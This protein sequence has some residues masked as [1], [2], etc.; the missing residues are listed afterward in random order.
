MSLIIQ[1]DQ[2]IVTSKNRC[3]VYSV[4]GEVASEIWFRTPALDRHTVENVVSIQIETNSHDQGWVFYPEA[5]SWSWFDLVVLESPDATQIKV[6]DGL[7]LVWMSHENKLGD[8]NDTKQAGPIFLGQHDIFA[9]LEVGNSLGVRVCAR[10][11]EWE[12]HALEARLILRVPEKDITSLTKTFDAYLDAAT[13]KEAP[14]AYSLVRE[15]L[16]MGPLRADEV[17]VTEEPPLRLLS[18]DGGGVRGISSLYILQAIMAK[19]SPDNPS[20]KPCE[21]FDM[22]CGTSTGGLIAIMLGRLQMTISECI[23]V[24]ESL[25]SDIF[26]AHRAQRTWNFST[27]G[28]YYKAKYFE[29]GLKNLIKEKTGD[30]NASMLD[31]DPKNKCKVFVVSAHSDNLSEK[32]EHF[33][34]Y[35]NKFPDPFSGC[36]IWQ[37]ARATSAAPMYLPPITINKVE[38][39][40]GGTRFNN[41]SILLMGEVNA[42]FGVA[43]HI[44]CLLSIGTGMQPHITIHSKPSDPIEVVS[45][46]KSII[47]A[48]IKVMT[49]CEMTHNLMAGLFYGKEDVYYR[50]NAGVKN[51]DDW[52]PTIDMDDYGKMTELVDLTKIY[53]GAKARR[54]AECAEALTLESWAKSKIA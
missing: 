29:E 54:I 24:Y 52:A 2:Y 23:K 27:T 26:S 31:P 3:D 13:P 18:F 14:P 37:A 15:M 30:E 4:S 33:R 49:D 45:Y 48:S 51:G 42:V 17:A 8:K 1:E 9:S 20:V 11:P 44:R 53:L 38:F 10:F 22:I 16:P 35:P 28:A 50:F 12:N 47:K 5:G 41:P 40:D 7:A 36:R 46:T 6:K 25:A 43:R 39:V 19:V 21:Y 32:A 34:T